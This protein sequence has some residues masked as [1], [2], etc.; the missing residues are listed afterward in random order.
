MLAAMAVTGRK[1]VVIF[2]GAYHGGVMTFTGGHSKMSVPVD[3][4]ILPYNDVD[5]VT[6]WFA[7]H[8]DRAAVIVQQACW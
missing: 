4:A 6:Q 1:T 5:A 8:G 3:W 7:E 2:D